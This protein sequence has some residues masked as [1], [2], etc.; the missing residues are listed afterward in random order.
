MVVNYHWK[1]FVL[2]L[3]SLFAIVIITRVWLRP[4]VR[5]DLD[6]YSS[7][8][9]FNIC[10]HLELVD[11]HLNKVRDVGVFATSEKSIA[12][13]S[14][15]GTSMYLETDDSVHRALFSHRKK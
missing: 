7:P 3:V 14:K 6:L 5:I 8:C 10:F 9:I 15:F 13:T 1:T 4:L 2:L 12:A 11:S